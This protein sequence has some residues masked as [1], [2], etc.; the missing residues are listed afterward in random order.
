M[1]DGTL[2]R[3][4]RRALLLG[5]VAA[6]AMPAISYGQSDA[7]RIGHLTPRTGFLGPLGEFAVQAVLLPGGE[8]PAEGG[9]GGGRV[10]PPIVNKDRSEERTTT[11][12]DRQ[13]ILMHPFPPK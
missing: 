1:S 3:F 4:G 12:Y 10:G 11:M 5:G 6:L 2:A 13:K 8:G 9:G 7:I